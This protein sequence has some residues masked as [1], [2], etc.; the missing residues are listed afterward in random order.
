MNESDD[1]AYV[2]GLKG[3]GMEIV[4]RCD[5][6]PLAIKVLGGLLRRKSRTR[7]A[8]LHI[9]SHDM[10]LTTEI[11]KDI[12]K[13]VYLSYEDLPSR[14]KQCFVYSSLFTKVQLIRRGNIVQ[15]WIAEGHIH[16]KIGSKTLES[17]GEEYYNELISR[18]L[19]RTGQRFLWSMSHA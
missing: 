6:L 10:W 8:W 3:I 17:L 7:D 13:A 1:E 14:L 18:N 19:T 5:C 12:N 2:D 11:N 16:Y 15:L 9:S 4:E